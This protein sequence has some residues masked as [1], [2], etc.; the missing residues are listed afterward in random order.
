MEITTLE[1]DD[2]II[3]KYS[4]NKELGNIIFIPV[5][6]DHNTREFLKR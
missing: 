5:L 1:R 2:K 3:Q 4:N 6:Y